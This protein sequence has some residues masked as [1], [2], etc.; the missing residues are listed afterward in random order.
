MGVAVVYNLHMTNSQSKTKLKQHKIIN[1]KLV[2]PLATIGMT[3][4][5]W[6]NDR[7]PEMLWAALYA[8]T[9]PRGELLKRFK[10]IVDVACRIT[11]T[12]KPDWRMKPIP[13]T[14]TGISILKE[15]EKRIMM[16]VIGEDELAKNA[17][18]PMLLLENLPDLNLWK[19]TIKVTPTNDDWEKLAVSIAGCFYH[20]SQKATD[21][22][23]VKAL[24]STKSGL[25]TF[26]SNVQDTP[27]LILDYATHNEEQMRLS[28]PTIRSFEIS[29]DMMNKKYNW[30]K[31]FWDECYK[32]T[33]C[34][35]SKISKEEMESKYPSREEMIKDRDRL[36]KINQ[37]LTDYFRKTNK[38]S[39]RDAKHEVAFGLAL[40]AADLATSSILLGIGRTAQGRMTLRSLVE[41]LILLKY[42][43]KK[44]DDKLWSSFQSHGTGQAKLVVQRLE[45]EERSCEYI[46]QEKLGQ[47]AN[48]DVWVEFLPVDI[49]DWEDSGLRQRAIYAGLK[50]KYDDYYTWSSS[51]CHGQWGAIR[52]SIF[53]LCGNPLH[54]FHRIP[55]LFSLSLEDTKEDTF[56]LLNDI[57][58]VLYEIYPKKQ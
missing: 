42:L 21:C 18:A 6:I 29:L 3:P 56:N 35:T 46:N 20:Q 33:G 38:G 51:Y 24:Y 1:K 4:S 41:C 57:V 19:S 11:D 9:F 2:P 40:Y 39:E 22:R 30:S 25:V 31:D 17:L 44:N 48:D 36:D 32:K 13:V 26:T 49:G 16:S 14:I 5:S 34:I 58:E 53:D 12:S 47:I 23:W 54:R 28:R 10:S 55:L 43:F 45:E 15:E 8:N 27:N 52:E 37:E 7:L 50:D